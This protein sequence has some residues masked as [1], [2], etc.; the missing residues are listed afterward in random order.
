MSSAQKVI[1]YLAI[2][3]A[4]FLIASILSCIVSLCSGL[5]HG[6]SIIDKPTKSNLD[7]SKYGTYLDINIK[8]ANLKIIESDELKVE[9]DNDKI[10]VKIEDNKLSIIDKNKF[11]S[12]HKDSKLIVYVPKNIKFDIVSID[13]G[14]GKIDIG[15]FN[16]KKTVLELGAGEANIN[17]IVSD[18]TIIETGAGDVS[19]N[20]SI[21]NNADLDLGVGNISIKSD[22]TGNSNI[23]CGIGKIKL[24]LPNN[25]DNYSFEVEK[26]IG[27]IKLNKKD[28]K[29]NEKV[30][31]GANS[32]KIDGGIGNITINTK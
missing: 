19:I 6:I 22:I 12:K 17:D 21:L 5:I 7:H 1:K 24:F 11:Y 8:Y 9:N 23:E 26:G 14:A 2:A 30:G 4:A 10:K 3:F 29:D 20:N 13:A 15:G 32:I 16:A 27:S 31:T 28:M 25:I 18:K